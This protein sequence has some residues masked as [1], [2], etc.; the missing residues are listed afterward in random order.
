MGS[1]LGRDLGQL[2]DDMFRRGA[3][4]IAHAEVDDVLAA[5][6]GRRAE[7]RQGA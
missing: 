6:P 5:R 3:I 7:I 4:R 2:V 1:R